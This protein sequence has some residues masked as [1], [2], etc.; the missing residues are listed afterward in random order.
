MFDLSFIQLVM[1]AIGTVVV[2]TLMGFSVA[3]FA[4]LLGD[5]G[6]AY[7]G[8]LTLNPFV[9]VDIFGLFGGTIGRGGWTRPIAID[10]AAGRMGRATPVIVALLTM[11][12]IFLFGRLVLLALPWV[13]AYWPASSAAFVD[14]TIRM[15]ADI[16][17]WTLAINIIPIPPLLGGYLLLSLAPDAHGWLVR[18]HL[19]VSIVLAV[20]VVLAYQSLPATPFGELARLLGAR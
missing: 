1:R 9:H 2:V 10:P 18:R 7:D 3:G 8:K 4:R 17:A 19:Y 14:A 20:L 11:A 6:T 16:A 13:A 12:A 15:T 5:K